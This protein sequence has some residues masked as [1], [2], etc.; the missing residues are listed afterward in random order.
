MAVAKKKKST[1]G[2]EP[3][4]NF[5]DT[6]QRL[7][8]IVEQLESGDLPLEQSLK[9]FEEG[10]RLSRTSQS[11]LDTAEQRIE[12]LLHLGDNDEPVLGEFEG[13]EPPLEGKEH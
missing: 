8:S 10:V 2:Q 9:L 7:G 12:K 11:A 1:N 4:T 13:K 6:V 5:E 3:P